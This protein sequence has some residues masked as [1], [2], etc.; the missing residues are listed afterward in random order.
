[1]LANILTGLVALIHIYIV[2]LEM[3]LWETPR[4]W[5]DLG[6]LAGQCWRPG[7]D[8]LPPLRCGRRS[9]WRRNSACP[10]LADPNNPGFDRAGGRGLDL[11]Q[12]PPRLS[13]ELR[14]APES[15]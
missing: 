13:A 10:H 3:V 15:R 4:G 9:L 7:E 5:T 11:R 6:H 14:Q 8:I 12:A 2:I 1:M